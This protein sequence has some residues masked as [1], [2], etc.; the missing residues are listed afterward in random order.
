MSNQKVNGS[1]IFVCCR[2]GDLALVDGGI[3]E[4]DVFN[5][6]IGCVTNISKCYKCKPSGR[7]TSRE[8]LF[9]V[10][11]TRNRGSL[12]AIFVSNVKTV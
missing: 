11:V 9:S 8:K 3:T 7:P 1:N 6:R 10:A 5:L 2:Y 4:L 12:I